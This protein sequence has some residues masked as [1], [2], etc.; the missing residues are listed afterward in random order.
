MCECKG[1]IWEYCEMRHQAHIGKAI[2][3]LTFLK[4][5]GK[6]EKQELDFSARGK[7]IAKLGKNG[8]ELVSADAGHLFF[9]RCV[10]HK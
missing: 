1:H 7:E 8:W 9:K 5:D 2:L 6:H 10:G 3:T 4:E